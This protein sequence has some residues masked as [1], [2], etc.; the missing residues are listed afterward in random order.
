[1]NNFVLY[2]ILIL[3]IILNGVS[4]TTAAN[5]NETVIVDQEMEQE[6]GS[7]TNRIVNPL[8]DYIRE[9]EAELDKR[10]LKDKEIKDLK[11]KLIKHESN[12][13][14]IKELRSQI[15][16][17]HNSCNDFRKELVNNTLQLEMCEN[18][19]RTLNS[20]IIENGKVM[21][22]LTVRDNKGAISL[23]TTLLQLENNQDNV[24]K[25]ELDPRLCQIDVSYP[26]AKSLGIRTINVPGID[27]FDVQCDSATIGFGWTIIQRRFK[28]DV[29]FNRNWAS[30]REGFGTFAGDFFLGLEKIHRLTNSGRYELYVHME[31]SLGKIVHSRYDN[32]KIAGE[33]DDYVL[34]SLGQFTGNSD[35]M[36]RFEHMKFSTFDHDRDSLENGNCAVMWVSGWWHG[37]CRSNNLNGVCANTKKCG[38][39]YSGVKMLIR[40]K[41]E[42]KIKK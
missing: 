24:L 22:N 29:N 1:M 27:S 35:Q 34:S 13:A 20:S 26:F 23:N 40:P 2:L 28:E 21:T 3:A 39:I 30:Y 31:D 36:R 32:F 11:E 14:I 6:Y 12:E 25:E 9:L 38:A 7:F 16:D 10:K 33:D 42:V 41:E 5:E 8:I 37:D 18:Q 19:L 17:L 15:V 4:I